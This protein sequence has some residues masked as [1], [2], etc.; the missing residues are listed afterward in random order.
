MGCGSSASRDL[1][2]AIHRRDEEAKKR[3]H[4]EQG[5]NA[6]L[7]TDDSNIVFVFGEQLQ[8]FDR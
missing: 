4:I 5:N 3:I 2:S 8:F 7:R 6:K 1:Q